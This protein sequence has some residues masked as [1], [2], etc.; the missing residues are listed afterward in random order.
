M[1]V[2]INDQ[3][4]CIP[5]Y[6]S[7]RWSQIAFIES[8][9]GDVQGHA[10]LKLHLVDGK[11]ISIPNLDQ[12]IID[13]A[14]HE[15]LLYLEASQTNKEDPLREDDKLGMLMNVLQQLTKNADIQIFSSKNFLPPLFAGEN[16][17]DA[18]LQHTPEHK[19]YPDAPADVLEKMVSVIR[20]LVGNTSSALLKPEPHCNCMYCPIGRVIHEEEN[21]TVSEQD[22][23]FRTWDII[24]SGDKLYVVS[25]PLNPHEQFSVYLGPPIGCTCGEPNCEH[26]KAVLYT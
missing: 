25:D 9:E 4:I 17:I 13:I 14:F 11:V 3:L 22:L 16:P 18:I 20:S 21:M 19:D 5:P 6:I 10:T 15:H 26:L 24:Q 8:Q 12:S 23:T 1:K 7:A 2:K